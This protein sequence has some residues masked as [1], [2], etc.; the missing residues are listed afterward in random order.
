[1][2]TYENSHT[3]KVPHIFHMTF[4]RTGC[5]TVDI[6]ISFYILLIM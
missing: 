4:T 2:A 1:V 5:N 3:S 6:Y